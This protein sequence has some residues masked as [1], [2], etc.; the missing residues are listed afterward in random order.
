MTRN[1]LA[2]HL[3]W[4]MSN[5]SSTKPAAHVFPAPSQ[6]SQAPPPTRS[7]TSQTSTASRSRAP[8]PVDFPPVGDPEV[9]GH[10][11][12]VSRQSTVEAHSGSSMGRLTSTTKSKKPLLVSQLPQQLPTPSATGDERA[13]QRKAGRAVQDA[14]GGGAST[15]RSRA[16]SNKQTPRPATSSGLNLDFT[17]FDDD[18]LEVMD[19]TEET[20]ASGGSLEFGDDVKLWDEKTAHWSSPAPCRSA[21]KRKCHQ[22]GPEEEFPDI[23]QILGTNP[24]A[25]TP[26]T[27]SAAGHHA[28]ALGSSRSRRGEAGNESARS[29]SAKSRR[30]ADL[31]L[32]IEEL[33]SPSRRVAERRD[34]LTSDKTPGSSSRDGPKRRRVSVEPPVFALSSGDEAARPVKPGCVPDSEDEFVTPPS[35]SANTR[36]ADEESGGKSIVKAEADNCERETVVGGSAPG[37]SAVDAAM[38]ALHSPPSGHAPKLLTLLSADEQALNR[39]LASLE[40]RIQQNGRDFSRAVIER[41]PREKRDAIK[42]E[43]ER[44]LKQRSAVAELSGSMESYKAICE[45]RESLANQVAQSYANGLDTDEDEIRLDELTDQVQEME[46]QLIRILTDA[47]LDRTSFFEPSNDAVDVLG[48]QPSYGGAMDTSGEST[49]IAAAGTQVVQ[50]TQ[51]PRPRRNEAVSA[52][53]DSWDEGVAQELNQFKADQSS[54]GK[55]VARHISFDVPDDLFS[56]LGDDDAAPLPAPRRPQSKSVSAPPNTTSALPR[57]RSHTDN[58]SDFSDDADMLAFAQDYETRQSGRGP[59]PRRS[60]QVLSPASGNATS[61][62]SKVHGS[63]KRSM[64]PASAVLSI[65]PELMR[66]PWSPEVQRILKD[67]FRMKGFRHNQ[68]EAINATLGG[69][70][71]FVL[72]PT[73]GGKSL[74]YQLPAVVKTGKTRGVTIVVSPLLSL[75]Q[76]QVEHMKALGIQA[77]AFNGECS[78]EYK[79]EVMSAFEERNPEHFV[80]L[81]YVTPEMVS[82]NTAFTRAMESL[83]RK[84]KFARLVIDEAHCVS[85]WGHDFRPDYKTLGQVRLKFP[86]VPVMALTATATKNVIVDIR[87]NLGMARCQTF[88]Q[89]FNRPN[90]FYEVQKKKTNADA[91]DKIAA[92]IKAKYAN[93]TGIVYT[94]SRKQAETVAETL[95]DQGIAARHYHAAI[96]PREKAQ[97][98]ASWQKGLV[99]VVVATIAFGMGIDKADVRFVM[100]HGLPKSLEG[101]YQETGRAGRDGK[102]SD[103]ILFFGKADIRVLKKLIQDGEGS[104]EQRERQMVM[105]N[106]VTSFCD[107]MADCRRSEVLRYFGEDIGPEQCQKQCDNCRS[108]LV[109]ELQDFST[110]A[111]AAIRVVQKQR[112]LTAVQCAEIL[113]G[114]K[115]PKNEEELSG[116]YFGVA[117]G[118]KKHELIRVIDRLSAEKALNEDNVVGN[119]GMAIQYLQIGPTARQFLARERQLKL[120]IQV[121]E[122]PAASKTGKTTRKKKSRQSPPVQSTYVSSPM[123]DRQRSRPQQRASSDDHGLTSNGYVNDGFVVSDQEMRDCDDDDDDQDD[124]DAFEPLP[125]HRPPRPPAVKVS[126]RRNTLGPQITVDER[127]SSL[128][129]IHQDLVN[130][131]VIEA[132]KVE[133]R[134]RNAK[135]LRRPLFTERDFREMAMSWTTS[136]DKMSRIPGIDAAKV[137]E[138]GPKL[139]PLLLQH[140]DLYKQILAA[141]GADQ[142][143]E[144]VDLISSEVEADGDD[145]DDGDGLA[146]TGIDSH[147]FGAPS[148]NPPAQTAQVQAF[149]NRL[150]GLESQQSASTP[151]SRPSKPAS[152]STFRGGGPN[153]KFSGRRWQKRS[154]NGGSS[155]GNG[156]TAPRRRP[157]AA[158][159]ARRASGSS[160]GPAARSA[161]GAG[162]GASLKR[163]GRLG[164]RAGGGIG[165]MPL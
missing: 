89:S 108:G 147:Y 103:C 144:V 119:H 25:S 127:L 165:L 4:L 14:G 8:D 30:V 38:A 42:S 58:F 97:V 60:R 140:H 88:S 133:E 44:L 106:R 24:P 129:E 96:E 152:S 47:G 109:F 95:R 87:H 29:H 23:Y 156:G 142:D 78:T 123:L 148:A 159:S 54:K 69:Q 40:S 50:Q 65:P 56:E 141:S 135:E 99:K 91:T 9:I 81:L 37:V 12:S 32:V 102:P 136:L 115:Y 85:Q 92:L 101:Y 16:Q 155:G 18:D 161:A 62:S 107:N 132:Q 74:C 46:Q 128:P 31:S 77:V 13:R 22:P 117:Q 105:L 120:S 76:D 154:G 11:L 43:K 82:K 131:F 45:R 72:M 110:Y 122:A 36:F 41:W 150:Q 63:P 49:V 61:S 39:C 19:L 53:E 48:T 79:R 114:K 83:Y 80:E 160:S 151:S 86:E 162:A 164:K 67:R 34:Q 20:V 104:A 98:L 84:G 157:S 163:D 112:R 28:S 71:A 118:L 113:L 126:G 26:R 27:G 55:A 137:A 52:E 93:A 143:D 125:K 121:D 3:T 145:D 10:G 6:L 68:L 90:L 94:I 158:A 64:P 116:D 17:G 59:T 134:I 57:A 33:S 100:H 138:H 1:N 7:Q 139:L 5:V 146:K 111:I 2:E 153:R 66:H 75:M 130:A 35:R 21:R 51:L 73:G 70:D 149:H 15:A 124:E